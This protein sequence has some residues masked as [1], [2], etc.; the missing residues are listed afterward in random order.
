MRYIKYAFWALVAVCLLVV[1]VAN[2]QPVELQALPKALSDLAGLA[3]TITLPLYI[4]IFIGV[5]FGLA[6]G[7]AWEWIR[8]H[9]H[10]AAVRTREREVNHLAREV[11][12]LRSEKHDGQD[13]ILALLDAPAKRA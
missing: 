8:E 6:I 1:A 4:A 11:E 5:A 7:F 10:R 13:D 12:K 9:K 2:S 3:P